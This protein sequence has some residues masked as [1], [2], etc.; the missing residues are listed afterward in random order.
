LDG[1]RDNAPDDGAENRALLAD[2][3]AAGVRGWSGL[4]AVSRSFFITDDRNLVSIHPSGSEAV[5]CGCDAE[6]IGRT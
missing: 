5:T 3:W 6:E 1:F 2:L 4:H